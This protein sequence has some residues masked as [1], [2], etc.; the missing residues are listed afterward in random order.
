[1]QNAVEPKKIQ[2]I[3]EWLG[4]G[5]INIF[6]MQLSGKDTQGQLLA[7]FLGAPVIGGGEILRSN[8]ISPEVQHALDNG[9][10][11]DS[12]EYVEIIKPYFAQERFVNKPLVLSSVG[13]SLGE[14]GPVMQAA[15]LSKHPLKA[16]ILLQIDE[17]DAYK[18]LSTAHRKRDDDYTENVKSRINE[19]KT[20]TLPVVDVYRNL[21]L[22]I[23]INGRHSSELVHESIVEALYKRALAERS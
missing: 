23:E 19:F 17:A 14:E 10:Y 2:A 11:I 3:K 4:A 5:S 7:D 16:A 21:G 1:M 8:P 18:R 6:G 20:K 9:L 15:K 12:E 22:L 13:R